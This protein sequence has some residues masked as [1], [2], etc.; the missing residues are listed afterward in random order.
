MR[1]SLNLKLNRFK[2][3][4]KV[5]KYVEAVP[6]EV[7]S[8]LCVRMDGAHSSELLPQLLSKPVD[9]ALSPLCLPT[10]ST[11]DQHQS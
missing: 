4:N 9:R 5:P 1:S 2:V 6:E 3:S 8:G 10:S 7:N 11:D